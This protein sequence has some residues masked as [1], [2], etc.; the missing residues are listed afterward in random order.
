MA[1]RS[2]WGS[3]PLPRHQRPADQPCRARPS[4]ADRTTI[5]RLCLGVGTCGDQEVLGGGMRQSRP[6][7]TPNRHLDCDS[8]GRRWTA[9]LRCRQWQCRLWWACLQ[10]RRCPRCLST[11]QRA[12]CRANLAQSLTALHLP[13][14]EQNR[15][16]SWWVSTPRRARAQAGSASV[17]L[18]VVNES[19][20][21]I[22]AQV[23]PEQV[24]LVSKG[25]LGDGH[26]VA[27]DAEQLLQ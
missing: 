19:R 20:L 13:R 3:R 6:Q 27:V 18:E 7:R 24:S 9:G 26:S 21:F 8:L 14:T 5:D 11:D 23:A 10:S 1:H 12:E 25:M 17:S 22:G 4:L 15:R 2:P 16:C